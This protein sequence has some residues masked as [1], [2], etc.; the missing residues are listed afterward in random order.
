MFAR[1]LQ[2]RSQAQGWG[3]TSIGAHPGWARTDLIANGPGAEGS[4]DLRQRLA[5]LISPLLSQSG[6]AGALPLL[7]AATSRD[8]QPGGFYGPDG[9]FEMKGFPGPA[10]VSARAQDLS[11]ARRLWQVSETLTGVAFGA[12]GNPA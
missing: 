10:K 11:V 6:A 12:E 5:A 7:Y 9:L 4:N 2:R 1:E 3:V 8:A